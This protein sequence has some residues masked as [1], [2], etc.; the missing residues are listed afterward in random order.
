MAHLSIQLL[1][2]F[3]VALDGDPV[4]AFE[5]DK[6]RALLAYLVVEADRPHRR[7]KL[8]GLL[9][10]DWP[11]RSARASL[12]Q[13]LYNLRAA[14]GDRTADPTFLLISA[15]TLQFNPE[16]HHSL[17]VARLTDL[18]QEA[19]A[20]QLDE[21]ADAYSGSFLAGFS[22]PDSAPFEEWVTTTREELGRFAQEAL[23]RL[24]AH[25]E[26]R[27]EYPQ[28][29]SYARRAVALDSTWEAGHRSVMRLLALSGERSA[30]LGH[31]ETCRR[32]L[33][34]EVGT[35][36]S[37]ETQAL[38]DLLSRG[39]QPAPLTAVPPV[40]DRPPR[41]IGR[42]PYRGLAAFREEDAL[43][44]F[45]RETF[46]ERLS[47]AV[48]RRP[49]VAV[50]VGSSGSGKSSAVYAGLLPRLRG[51]SD[52]LVIQ[53]RPGSQPFHALAAAILPLLEPDLDETDRLIRTRRL[54]EALQQDQVPLLDAVQR[55][56]E[57]GYE[58]K[59]ALLLVD[60]FEE[61]YTL[62]PDPDEQR[63][64]LDGLLAAVEPGGG[65]RGHPLV[66]LLT[67]RADF[68]GQA[69]TH[70]PFADALQE[71]ALILGPMTRD[72][73]RAAIERPAEVQGAAFEEGLVERVLDDVG[74]EP[75]NLPLLEFALTLLWERHR[76][77]WL[78]HEAYE[79]IG[80]VEGALA[81]Y[82]DQVYASA[83][84]SLISC[85]EA[86]NVISYGYETN[87]CKKTDGTR[88]AYSGTR[89]TVVICFHSA[90]LPD[91]VEQRSWQDG[92]PDRGRAAL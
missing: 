56:L 28:A 12:S 7:E 52:W 49:L 20:A 19:T 10:P 73:L 45:G 2:S 69:L 17:D 30:A 27:G 21:A 57:K 82:A 72:E 63:R 16:S 32:L 58:A 44:F 74:D 66:V 35:E 67:L 59:R 89:S 91:T 75:G 1:G 81:R 80:R 38:F 62:C 18:P 71:N 88:T 34:A 22:L 60:Q 39:E 4:T 86:R 43:F 54:G 9:W 50:I 46:V 37:D 90:P 47:E 15:Q 41:A 65:P 13:A 24:A 8:T 53:L 51:E 31:Y 85:K 87:L 64:F 79:E 48:R 14:I 11:E 40:P 23:Q 84:T 68:M 83:H 55:A 76:Y 5:S 25:H 92:E 42:C 26:S 3:R 78:T 33:Q 36:P 77:G 6:V 29:L 70:R 61:L